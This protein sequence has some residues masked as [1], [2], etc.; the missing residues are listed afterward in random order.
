MDLFEGKGRRLEGKV[1]VVTGGSSGIGLAVAEHRSF[2][3]AAAQVGIASPTMS[4]TIRS[5]EEGLGVRL[6]NRTPRSV[7]LTEAGD[8]L[9]AEVQSILDGIDHVVESVNAFRDKPIGTLRLAIERSA[10]QIL[11]ARGVAPLIRSFLD[12]YPEVRVEIS[13]DDTHGDI[14]SGRF[15]AG[16]RLGQ[17]I[18]RD[19]TVLR[20]ADDWRVLTVATPDYLA[21]R[22]KPTV[23][24]I[25]LPTTALSA[26]RPGMARHSCGATPRAT[27]KS[28]SPSTGRSLSTILTRCCA[29]S[30]DGVGKQ[31]RPRRAVFIH[32]K[33]RDFG[34]GDGIRTLDPILANLQCGEL[35]NFPF[36]QSQE[37]GVACPRNHLYRT[38][39]RIP[40]RRFCFCVSSLRRQRDFHHAGEFADDLDLDAAALGRLHRNPFDQPADDLQ[41]LC[42]PILA[43]EVLSQIRH[44]VTVAVGKVRVQPDGTRRRPLEGV[45]EPRAFGF[46]RRQSVLQTVPPQAVRDGRDQ[47]V[48]LAADLLKSSGV[49]KAFLLLARPLCVHPGMVGANELGH[50]IRMHQV[51]LQRLENEVLEN[52]ATDAASIVAKPVA[53]GLGAAKIVATD[54]GERMAAPAADRKPGQN[55]A[56]APLLPE[57][58]LADRDGGRRLRDRVQS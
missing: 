3:K 1:A 32:L 17:R 7:A 48:E 13:I 23:P 14:I 44:A 38:A 25:C 45:L 34:M 33:S 52:L 6:F 21:R 35:G 55:V 43:L 42:S 8:R 39:F 20:I 27:S 40:E 57:P 50:E 18:E 47:A 58:A 9:L 46:Q 56:R 41:R 36:D 26:A 22:T 11:T 10:A 2:T 12:E 16:I 53:V 19:M 31:K 30:F 51:L 28:K 49:G 15:D 24:R 29:T 54:R 4:Q 37:S 5:L